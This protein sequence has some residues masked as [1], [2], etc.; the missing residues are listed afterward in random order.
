[1]KG[2]GKGGGGGGFFK[3]GLKGGGG[4]KSFGRNE[5]EAR[6]GGLVF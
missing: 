6:N 4:G 2:E 1:M 5:A 3:K